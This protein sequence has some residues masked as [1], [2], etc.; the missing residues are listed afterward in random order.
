MLLEHSLKIKERHYGRGHVQT[1]ATLV[2]LAGVYSELGDVPR[3]REL[4]EWSLSIEERHFGIGHVETA[5]TLNNL[6]LACGE[7]GDVQRMRELLGKSLSIKE[8]H[9]GSD[10]QELCLTLSNMGMAC[11][12][13]GE[14]VKAEEMC[15][16]AMCLC[17]VAG[18]VSS[19]R[20]G[21]VLLRAASV[22]LALSE[23]NICKISSN[24]TATDLLEQATEVLRDAL[25]TGAGAR[26]MTLETGRMSRIWSAAGRADVAQKLLSTRCLSEDS[27]QKQQ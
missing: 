27:L 1:T 12:A 5:I 4:L 15:S 23:G 24:L 16:R 6:A 2:N 25:G 11:G 20:R 26:V 18:V 3:A 9:F 7:A 17:N 14:N 8:N 21:V 22:H 19:R 10:H 13:L